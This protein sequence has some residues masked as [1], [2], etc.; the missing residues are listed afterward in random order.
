LVNSDETLAPVEDTYCEA[1]EGIFCRLMITA[2][3][4][5]TLHAAA[6]DATATPSVVIGRTEGGVERY[7]N[8]KETPD[9]RKGA[10]VQFWAETDPK[11][12]F[13]DV[14]G[15]FEKELSYR[16][17][18]DILVKPFTA[19]FDALEK[20]EA[21]M[22][23]MERVGHCGDGY[24]WTEKRY[25]K[26]VIVV[27]LMVPDFIIEQRIGYA[28]GV[29]GGNFW[30]MC[31]TKEALKK[32]GEKALEAIHRVPG[33]V[34][35]FDVCS[36]GSK[37]ETH[38]PQIGPTTNH[39]YCPSLKRQLG[40]ASRVP[41]GVNYI[42]EIVVSGVSMNAVRKAMRLGIDAARRVPGVERIT[43]GNYGG[44]LGKYQINLRELFL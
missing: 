35:P 19:V 7:L 12:P 28:H 37:P 18:Q 42:P 39:L 15:K 32:S 36:A 20:A 24:E 13:A 1:F 43:A 25:R 27:P 17:R 26:K 38:F 23:M 29:S 11:K 3:D 10:I 4:E 30:V 34:T 40:E 21:Q 2:D 31:T 33:V 8:E 22:D 16:I 44:K 9:T 6:E 5:K 41:E 14:L